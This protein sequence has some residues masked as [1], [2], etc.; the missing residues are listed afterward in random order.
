M[1]GG[2]EWRLV[3]T[4]SFFV[5]HDML[6]EGKENLAFWY[7]WRFGVSRILHLVP[8]PGLQAGFVNAIDALDEGYER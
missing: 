2:L 5:L 3:R 7:N 4:S 6:G 8:N 1:R